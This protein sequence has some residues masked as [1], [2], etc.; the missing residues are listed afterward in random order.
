LIYRKQSQP[1]QTGAYKSLDAPQG[2]YL[3]DRS[4]DSDRVIVALNFL[5]AA[6]DVPLPAGGTIALSTHGDRAGNTVS[7]SVALRP[8]EGVIVELG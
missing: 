6:L 4:T 1:L 8:E 7:S 5:G 2:C 3:Y